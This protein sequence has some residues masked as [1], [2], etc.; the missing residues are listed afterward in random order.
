MEREDNIGLINIKCTFALCIKMY[1]I[2]F[3]ALLLQQTDH[4]E[5][6]GLANGAGHQPKRVFQNIY[7]VNFP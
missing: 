5:P 7:W 2:V 4:F 3:T 6:V 1:V